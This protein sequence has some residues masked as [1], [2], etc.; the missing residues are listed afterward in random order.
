MLAS[1]PP[2]PSTT[3][4]DDLGITGAHGR[5]RTDT[6]FRTSLSD[7]RVCHF[8]TRAKLVG[9]DGFEPSASCSR[10][11]RSTRLSYTPKRE[12][13]MRLAVF[14]APGRSRTDIPFYGQQILSLPCLPFHHGRMIGSGTRIR[15]SVCGSRARRPPARRFRKN[16]GDRWD[17]NPRCL[18]SHPRFLPLE[19]GRHCSGASGRTRTGTPC[20]R[21]VL[22]TLCLPIPPQKQK[23]VPLA[24]VEPA[25]LA[26]TVSKTAVSAISP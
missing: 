15:T 7:W 24:G 8:T 12:Q 4:P 19:D 2:S 1:T 3:T 11:R 17:S 26:A 23:L 10:S 18:G 25:R 16:W 21:R 9:E 20:R 22:S 13:G 6:R 5:T 14:G